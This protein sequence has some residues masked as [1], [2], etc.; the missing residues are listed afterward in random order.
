M[1]KNNKPSLKPKKSKDKTD[2]L[3]IPKLNLKGLAKINLDDLSKINLNDLKNF[4]LKNTSIFNRNNLLIVCIIILLL[5]MIFTVNSDNETVTNNTTQ[6]EKILPSTINIGNNSLG[7][8]VK[9]GPYGNTSSDVK[10]AYILGVH[11]REKGAH[12]LMEQ[13]FKEKA[14]NLNYCYYIYKVNVTENPTGFSASRMNGQ[15]LAKEFIV[16]DAISNNITFAVD[17]H[18][19]NGAWGVE[20][21]IFTPDKKNELS[22][23][24][25]KS[26]ADNFDWIVYFT[27]DNPTSPRYLTGPLNEGGVA[28][29]IYEAYTEDNNNVTLEHDRELIDYIDNWN[30]T[31]SINNTTS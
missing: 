9:E 21:F 19:S 24:L 10:I 11:P 23:T 3:K 20:R 31:S 12:K 4:D 17:S 26:I 5:I 28:A 7:Y 18:Y 2:S 30:F 6:E 22:Y 1:T 29:V 25:S 8:V 27:P 15:K 13:S 16:P 14:D